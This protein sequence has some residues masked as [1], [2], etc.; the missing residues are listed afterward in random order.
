MTDAA[1]GISA[2]LDWTTTTFANVDLRSALHRAAAG[3]VAGH[4]RPDDA[5][6]HRAPAQCFAVLFDAD[7]AVGRSAQSLFV[8]PR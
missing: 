6:R 8:A 7:G 5:R 2:V 1:S 3:R 4:G